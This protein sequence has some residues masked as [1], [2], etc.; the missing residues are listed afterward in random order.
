MRQNRQRKTFE[1]L[2]VKTLRRAIDI[3]KNTATIWRSQKNMRFI[4]AGIRILEASK[5]NFYSLS[6][7]RREYHLRAA[8][9]LPLIFFVFQKSAEVSTPTKKKVRT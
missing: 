7:F 8:N 9:C 2:R 4:F 3:Q 5:Q 1:K 6:S